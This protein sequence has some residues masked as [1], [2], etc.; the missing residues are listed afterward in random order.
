MDYP[1]FIFAEEVYHRDIR[2]YGMKKNDAS[3]CSVPFATSHIDA[4]GVCCGHFSATGKSILSD[5]FLQKRR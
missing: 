2:D 3:V 5:C 4:T 1:V